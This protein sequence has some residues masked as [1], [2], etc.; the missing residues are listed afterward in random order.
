M[1]RRRSSVGSFGLVVLLAVAPLAAAAQ[2]SGP[3]D[4]QSHDWT[5]LPPNINSAYGA[6]IDNLYYLIFYVTGAMFILTEGVLLYFVIK[7]RRREG[8]KA[9][10]SHGNTK[11]EITWTVIPGLMLFGLALLQSSTWAKARAEFPTGP[12]VV[13]IQVM[14]QQFEW[15]FRY[16]GNDNSFGTGDD[17]IS[18]SLHIPVGKKV[19]M[20][21]SS[22]DVI[23]SPFL[24]HLRVKQDILPGFMTKVWF[25]A[26]HVAVWDLKQKKAVFIKPEALAGKNVVVDPDLKYFIFE[27]KKVSVIGMREYNYLLKPNVKEVPIL[28]DGKV[29]GMWIADEEEFD[30]KVQGGRPPAEADHVLYAIDLACAELC[31]LTHYKMKAR[32]YIDTQASWDSWMD[33]E[34]KKLELFGRGDEVKRWQRWDTRHPEWNK[35]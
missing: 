2:D 21:M 5:G 18:P 8:G 22:K 7:Y 23:H 24:P 14:G 3:I 4:Y 35:P 13:V 29:F 16:P 11:A 19:V 20:K 33:R 12:D 28:R 32:V 1:G 27:D 9:I 31:G 25:I 30:V 6:E 34:Q 10:Y 17:I 15:S 26:D